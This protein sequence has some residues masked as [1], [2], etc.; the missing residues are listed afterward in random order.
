[1][2]NDEDLQQRVNQQLADATSEI[3]AQSRARDYEEANRLLHAHG[4]S[5]GI[6]M[7]VLGTGVLCLAAIFH[8]TF[9]WATLMYMAAAFA[10]WIAGAIFVDWPNWLRKRLAR[11]LLNRS[12]NH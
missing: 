8:R 12:S 10:L 4:V 5:F 2:S 11:K 6:G 1:M 7:M 9:S 3:I